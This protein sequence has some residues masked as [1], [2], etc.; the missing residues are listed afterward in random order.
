MPTTIYVIYIYFPMKL[1]CLY[2]PAPPI[3]SSLPQLQL[4]P[5]A[6]PPLTTRTLFPA[7]KKKQ[8]RIPTRHLS[9]T[10]MG[11]TSRQFVSGTGM[12]AL[13]N[14][15]ILTRR[16]TVFLIVGVWLSAWPSLLL[17]LLFIAQL[18]G[19]CYSLCCQY[20]NT[21]HNRTRTVKIKIKRRG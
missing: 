15:P 14:G 6:P 1:A 20:I 16:V 4:P 17:S 9:P 8:T 5:T 2:P 10:G 21:N 19:S 7:M 3:L 18:L 11:P 12:R 13:S